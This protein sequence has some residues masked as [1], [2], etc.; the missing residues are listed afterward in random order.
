MDL[1]S[2]IKD[3]FMDLINSASE[4]GS[5]LIQNFIDGIMA[6]WE[7]LKQTVANVAQT[8]K[9]F[10]GF[11]EPKKGPMSSFN[12]WPIHMMENYSHG[13]EN[14]KY[15]VKNAV[16]DVAADVS[17]LQSP[18]DSAELYEAVRA[19]A[20]NAA[21]SFAIGDREFTRALRDMGVQFNG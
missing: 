13:I 12:D 7:A 16:A 8:V 6:K 5:H 1:G 2:K 9:D 14:A 4:W 10:L 15:L 11:T 3:G 19:G 17:V 18:L 21:I 20:S